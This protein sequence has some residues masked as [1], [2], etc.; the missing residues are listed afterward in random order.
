MSKLVNYDFRRLSSSVFKSL[1]WH[2]D[3]TI[4]ITSTGKIG[5]II[6]WEDKNYELIVE[7]FNEP[8]NLYD[9]DIS[10]RILTPLELL[11]LQ[12]QDD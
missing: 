10:F 3:G 6:E 12:S 4:F 1:L 5:T 7:W 2:E 11:A 8:V 9:P